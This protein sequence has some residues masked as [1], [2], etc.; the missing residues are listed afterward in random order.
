MYSKCREDSVK[1]PEQEEWGEGGR[2]AC[3]M[4]LIMEA[5]LDHLQERDMSV[6]FGITQGPA[7]QSNGFEYQHGELLGRTRGHRSMQSGRHSGLWS[8][9]FS[10][11]VRM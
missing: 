8:K 10:L 1:D 9:P 2:G 11:K 6:N 3:G 7:A 5:I 4:C